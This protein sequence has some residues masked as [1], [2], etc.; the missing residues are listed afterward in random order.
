MFP[1]RDAWP[2]AGETNLF[3]AFL[4]PPDVQPVITGL[5]AVKQRAHGLRGHVMDADRL[6]VTV[7]CVHDPERTRQQTL[8]DATA[9][10]D[11]LRHAAV[12]LSF[13]RTQSFAGGDRFPLVLS[14]G[15]NPAAYGFQRRLA[16]RLRRAGFDVDH[17]FTPHVTMLW[18]DRPVGAYP[19]APITWMAREFVL[20][21]SARGRHVHL[22]RWALE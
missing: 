14:G 16:G 11:R 6:H 22:G 5:C 17:R 10:A 12:P 15:E 2:L 13:D 3:F 7:T 21:E 19:I 1:M 8:T 18:A 4:P 9:V 20:V